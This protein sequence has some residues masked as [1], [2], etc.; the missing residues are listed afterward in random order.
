L[1]SG[2]KKAKVCA[3]RTLNAEVTDIAIVV[4]NVQDTVAALR[5]DNANLMKRIRSYSH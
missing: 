5:S 1:K 2:I 3:K 4:V